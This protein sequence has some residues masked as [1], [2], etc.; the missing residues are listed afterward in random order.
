MPR[1]SKNVP[2]RLKDEASCLATLSALVCGTH[3]A[4]YGCR[5]VA[6]MLQRCW[7]DCGAARGGSGPAAARR[8]ARSR[9]GA[10]ARRATPAELSRRACLVSTSTCTCTEERRARG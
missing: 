2:T 5:S 10:A 1:F 7:T 9:K 6:L 8:A 4:I 3:G